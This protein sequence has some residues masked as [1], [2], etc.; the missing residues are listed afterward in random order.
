MTKLS[1]VISVF[2]EE[3]K[4][5]ECLSSASFADEIILVD[6]GSSD[7]TVEKAKKFNVKI[8]NQENDSLRIDL[9]KNFG[10]QKATGDWILSLD[11]DERISKELAEEIRQV[12]KSNQSS[13]NGYWI[14]RKNIIFNKWIKHTGWYPDL[15]LRLFKKGKGEYIKKAVHKPLEIEGKTGELKNLLIHKR[16]SSLKEFIDKTINIYAP[17]EAERLLSEGYSVSVR[18]AI[19]FPAQEFIS[20]F[21][22]RKGYKDGL[23]GLVLSIL[24]AFYHFFIFAYLWEKS[25]FRKQ[26]NILKE[27]E[28]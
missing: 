8:Y 3:E 26:E 10:F 20:R 6:N 23:H 9:Q 15:Q 21:F 12:L 17:S 2:N 16:Y 18:D 4:I 25:G 7:K 1:V 13:I 5:E 19:R 22:A 24:M 27:T 28:T 14:P 11:A